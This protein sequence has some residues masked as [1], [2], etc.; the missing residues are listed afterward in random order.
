MVV[1]L[2]GCAPRV[3][4]LVSIKPVTPAVQACTPSAPLPPLDPAFAPA[5][6]GQ[7]ALVS[8]KG[9]FRMSANGPA[10]AWW[11]ADSA[12]VLFTG[13]RVPDAWRVADGSFVDHIP[14]PGADTGRSEVALSRDARWLIVSTHDRHGSGGHTCVLDRTAH[15]ERSFGVAL[16]HLRVEGDS[17]I[18]DEAAIVLATGAIT[19]RD[20][21]A[22]AAEPR[23]RR[24]PADMLGANRS[25][26]SHDGRYLAG[27]YEPP[28]YLLG[29][30]THAHHGANREPATFLAL[31]DADTGELKWKIPRK[32]DQPWHFSPG[33]R[34]LEAADAY[35]DDVVRVADGKVLAFGGG[36][37]P[38][39]PDDDHVI[40]YESGPTLWSLSAMQRVLG[41]PRAREVV[42]RSRDGAVTAV[43]ERGDLALE[44]A[45]ACFAL[46]V[47]HSPWFGGDPVAF[48]PDGR[49][50]YLG[51]DGYTTIS[52]STAFTWDTSTG[53]L[54][55]ATTVDGPMRIFP[56]AATGG[57]AFA[58]A[59]GMRVVDAFSGAIVG[60]VAAPR[61]T[62]GPF[63]ASG[64]SRPVRD[65]GGDH[66]DALTNQVAVGRDGWH[67]AGLGYN[68]VS[69]WDLRDPRGV[70]DLPKIQ[71]E[72]WIDPIAWSDDERSIAAGTRGGRVVLW[73]RDRRVIPI[74]PRHDDW[75]TQLAFS[76]DGRMLASAGKDGVVYVIDTATGATIG[77]VALGDDQGAYLWWSDSELVINTARRFQIVVRPSLARGGAGG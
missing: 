18:G 34:Y 56:L 8:A 77:R 22:R 54:V 31:W 46:G 69:L 16:A 20:P 15:V 71:P 27:W 63:D 4:E 44:R 48:S 76:H 61:W 2:L 3:G 37:L 1:V 62:Q 42:A 6:D 33:D 24:A 59:N 51:H 28:M 47:E 52:K 12:I 26:W 65:P 10:L 29:G 30:G 49:Y 23:E 68:G 50:F 38:I 35:H 13:H 58:V 36:M 19:Q 55:H 74:A 41:P 72:D 57:F 60:A 21:P 53:A 32:L 73:T 75:V 17:A 70:V 14:C 7:L 25:M 40:V 45:G 43:V 39:A 66:A 64:T 9:D 5:L 67:L 11:S